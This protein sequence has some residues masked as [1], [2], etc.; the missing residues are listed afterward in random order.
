MSRHLQTSVAMVLLC[1]V[2]VIA[3]EPKPQVPGSEGKRAYDDLAKYYADR[4]SAPPYAEALGALK[5]EDPEARRKAGAYL[6]ALFAQSFADEDNGREAGNGP[7]I[8]ESLDR[9]DDFHDVYVLLPL[10]VA[11]LPMPANM[12]FSVHTGT[13]GRLVL[14]IRKE[15]SANL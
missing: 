12:A 6:L 4:K 13:G 7:R 5:G 3:E 15:A 9:S 11:L 10:A 14:L 8:I 1:S 2:S